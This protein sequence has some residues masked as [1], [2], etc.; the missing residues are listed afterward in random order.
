MKAKEYNILE[1]AVRTG[2]EYGYMRA[3][4]HSD[5]P[6]EGQIK[7]TIIKAVMDNIGEWFIFEELTKEYGQ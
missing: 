2:V 4:K 1:M 6:S 3:H 5:S 7:E